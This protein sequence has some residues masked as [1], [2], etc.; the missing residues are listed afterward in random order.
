V[1]AAY[2]EFIPFQANLIYEESQIGLCQTREWI[3]EACLHAERKASI[4]ASDIR[5]TS[6]ALV[7]HSYDLVVAEVVTFYAPPGLLT[8]IFDCL[9]K[10]IPCRVGGMWLSDRVAEAATEIIGVVILF[11]ATHRIPVFPG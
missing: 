4:C 1:A 9:M 10:T 2:L 8:A 5:L 7:N 6:T 11:I 3:V